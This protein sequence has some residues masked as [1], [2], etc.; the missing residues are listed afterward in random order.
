MS[1]CCVTKVANVTSNSETGGSQSIEVDT[2]TG[3]VVVEEATIG[4]LLAFQFSRCA[5]LIADIGSVSRSA[6]SSWDNSQSPC[7]ALVTC[8]GSCR[9]RTLMT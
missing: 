4:P 5:A 2:Q 6:P 1:S 7:V 3:E 8:M 9:R